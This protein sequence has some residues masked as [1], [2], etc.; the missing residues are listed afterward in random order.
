MAKDVVAGGPWVCQQLRKLT[1]CFWFEES[2]KGLQQEIFERL[3]TLTRLEELT[4]ES[5]PWYGRRGM[6]GR[7]M[8]ATGDHQGRSQ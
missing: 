5:H 6:D 1:A 2:E 8:E 4:L 7:D 3:S